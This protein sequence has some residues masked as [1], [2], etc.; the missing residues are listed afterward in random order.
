[1]KG[2]GAGKFRVKQMPSG[3]NANDIRAFLR[4]YINSKMSNSEF[5]R[6]IR[7][8]VLL[9][10][11]YTSNYHSLGRPNSE[12]LGNTPLLQAMIALE[13]ITKQFRKVNNLD[14]VNL[15]IIHDGDADNTN[16]IWLPTMKYPQCWSKY[17]RTSDTY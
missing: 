13:P 10:E 1:M 2:K 4:E 16:R 12:H 11:S 5:N 6:C 7:N 14:L 17:R 8:L 9:K 3:I 15:V